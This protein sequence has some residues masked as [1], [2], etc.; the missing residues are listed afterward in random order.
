MIRYRI[1]HAAYTICVEKALD[2]KDR[3][4]PDLI[5]MSE[6]RMAGYTISMVCYLHLKEYFE[7]TIKLSEFIQQK[8]KSWV[9]F[10]LSTF[11]S[12]SL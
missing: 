3:L 8:T 12:L 4:K 5:F 9:I 10:N 7:I 1:I 2:R 6:T 11:L